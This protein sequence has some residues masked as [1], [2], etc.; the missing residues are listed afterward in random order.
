MDAGVSTDPESLDPGHPSS[1]HGI[2]FIEYSTA[3]PL[4][5]GHVLELMGF[6][7]VARHRSREVLLYRQ[8]TMNV[9]INAHA[10]QR[11]DDAADDVRISA[12]AFRARD[13]A[14]A[15][16]HALDRGAWAVPTH[17]E[18]MELNIPAIHGVGA[19]RIYFV[20]RYR[21][22]SIYTVDFVPIPCVDQQ[23]PAVAGLRWFGLVQHVGPGRMNDWIE[24]YRE[25]FGFAPIPDDQRFGILPEGRILC[26]P[27]RTFYLQLIE[28]ARG[29]LELQVDERLARLGL[30]TS[31]VLE[32][33]RALRA[34]GVD[35]I[36]SELRGPAERGALTRGLPAGVAFELVRDQRPL[37]SG[38]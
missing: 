29:A 5:L 25:L 28:P 31:D 11:R 33:V 36:D 12:V 19:S 20:D 13:A 2:E 6:Q 34:R 8:G 4:A 7:P 27:C 22:F 35:F 32:A 14:A 23:P 24:F 9:V 3:R 16:R 21:E 38:P 30:G 26:S 37:P 1:L 10:A 15:Y 18:V 17:V